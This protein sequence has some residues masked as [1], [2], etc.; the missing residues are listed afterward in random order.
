MLDEACDHNPS[1]GEQ[2]NSLE[3]ITAKS[4]Q[5]THEAS[6]IDVEWQRT[7]GRKLLGA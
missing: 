4:K 2:L 7:L 5:R 1:H 3:L 6:P